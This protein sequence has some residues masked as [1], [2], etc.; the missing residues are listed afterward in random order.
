MNVKRSSSKNKSQIIL[1]FGSILSGDK[2]EKGE[3][4]EVGFPGALGPK[5]KM[6]FK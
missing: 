1:V 4:G 2:G 5:G 3:I 6:R